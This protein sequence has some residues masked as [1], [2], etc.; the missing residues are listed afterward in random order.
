MLLLPPSSPRVTIQ[1]YLLYIFRRTHDEIIQTE[2][3]FYDIF[4]AV[5]GTYDI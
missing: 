1:V 3:R 4:A 5:A 2:I